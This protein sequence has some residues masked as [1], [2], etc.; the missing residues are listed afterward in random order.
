MSEFRKW[1]VA[2]FMVITILVL[3]YLSNGLTAPTVN[4]KEDSNVDISTPVLLSETSDEMP[5][6]ASHHYGISEYQLLN[7]IVSQGMVVSHYK[8]TFKNTVRQDYDVESAY[9]DFARDMEEYK[10]NLEK[11]LIELKS[12]NPKLPNAKYEQKNAIEKVE[13]LYSVISDYPNH[14][15]RT[16]DTVNYLSQCEYA[17]RRVSNQ[18]KL[19]TE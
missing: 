13:R 1:L 17:L 19:P 11:D 7:D 2:S 8:R 4:T 15:N 12:L 5:P 16:K 9:A 3:V 14:L 10:A 6:M 18:M